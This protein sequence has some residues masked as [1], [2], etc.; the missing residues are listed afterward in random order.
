MDR[1]VTEQ[2]FRKP[3]FVGQDPKD[4]EFRADGKIVRKDRWQKAVHSIRYAMGDERREFEINEI[5]AAVRGMM[6][7]IERPPE[8]DEKE[9]ARG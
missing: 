2:D 5:I 1:E 6:A 7:G 4:Y 9:L 3:E 8:E